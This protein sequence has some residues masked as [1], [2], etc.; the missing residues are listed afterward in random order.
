MQKQLRLTYSKCMRSDLHKMRN[1]LV[2][3]ARNFFLR[4]MNTKDLVSLINETNE[5]FS[6]TRTDNWN[7]LIP[8]SLCRVN[9]IKDNKE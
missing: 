8:S 6:S 2:L 1:M 4:A 5:D 9:L 7:F 3:D